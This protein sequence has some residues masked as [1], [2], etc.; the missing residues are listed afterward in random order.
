MN[1]QIRDMGDARLYYRWDTLEYSII[2]HGYGGSY[3]ECFHIEEGE[4]W[5]DIGA[6]IGS[7]SVYAAVH[8]AKE[9]HAYEPV[10]STYEVLLKN[11]EL[12]MLEEIVTP[13]QAA[14]VSGYNDTTV[15]WYQSSNTGA[16][17]MYRKSGG[18]AI[19]V[20]SI[21]IYDINFEQG[22]CIKMDCEGAE[23]Q[24]LPALDFTK[25]DKLVFEYHHTIV[26]RK[27]RYRLIMDA[28]ESEF[29]KM[30][31][32]MYGDGTSMNWAWR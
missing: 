17:S 8:G 7:F 4:V 28:I 27:G 12:N 21:D 20:A 15:L 5:Y 18:V 6:N 14:M 11:I 30:R 2:E 1:L 23:E 26:S 9:V 31:T 22:C 25:V 13:Y 3:I 10:P 32:T 16:S 19:D 24:L 29:P